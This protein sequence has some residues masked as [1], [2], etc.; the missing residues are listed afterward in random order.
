MTTINIYSMCRGTYSSNTEFDTTI[1]YLT[2]CE[3]LVT[4][5]RVNGQYKKHIYS[6]KKNTKDAR[7][8]KKL[9]TSGIACIWYKKQDGW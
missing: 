6:E 7:Q 5:V 4:Y 2:L 3:C 1:I 9:G 8:K